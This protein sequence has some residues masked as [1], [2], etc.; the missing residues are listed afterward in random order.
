MI[1]SPVSN[2]SLSNYGDIDTHRGKIAEPGSVKIKA[3]YERQITNKKKSDQP[4][5]KLPS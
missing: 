4:G 2:D 3:P 5:P 1:N